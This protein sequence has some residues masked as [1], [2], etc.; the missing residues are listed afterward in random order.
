MRLVDLHWL[1][2]NTDLTNDLRVFSQTGD[3][4]YDNLK[5]IAGCRLDFLQ[6][7]RADRLLQKLASRPGADRD[8]GLKRIRLAILS[9]STVDH[10]EPGLRVAA[11]RHDILLDVMH[12][13][14]GQYLQELRTD[15][16]AL[17]DFRPDV[18]LLSLDAPHLATGAS[19]GMTAADA[20]AFVDGVLDR[21]VA[22][23]RLAREK[24]RAQVIQQTALP[25]FPPLMGSNEA[26]LPGSPAAIVAAINARLPQAAAA[27]GV[28]LLAL[29]A[30]VARDGLFAW[31]DPVLWHRAKQELSPSAG[32][33][34][35]ELVARLIAAQQGKS[36]KCLVLDLDNTLWGGVIGDDG[37]EGIR[38]GQGSTLGEAFVDFQ[39]YARDLSRRGVILAVVSKNDLANAQAP[40][41]SHPDMVLKLT[42]IACFI[43]NWSDKAGNI[44]EVAERLNI[45]LDSLVFVDD[46]PFERNIVRRELP[47]V[48]VPEITDDPA[49]YARAVADGG[50]FEALQITPEDLER[51]GQYRANLARDSLRESHTDLEGYLR[52]LDMVLQ[53]QRFDRIGMQR[54]V[55]LINKTNQFNLRTRRYTDEQVAALVADPACLTLQLRLLDQFGDNGIIGIVIG[56]PDGDTML[57]DTWLM[58]CRVLGRQVEEATMNIVAAEAKR[59]G[60]SQLVGEYIP[61]KKNGMVRDHYKKL[62]FA[63]VREDDGGASSWRLDLA[64]FSPFDTFIALQETSR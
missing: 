47:M 19:P 17:Q 32:P 22:C 63:K 10:L 12:G 31:H 35:G 21:L 40:F 55:Q 43:A 37:L 5:K 46:N 49:L 34:Y 2:V 45:G 8:A 59:L 1:P 36:S 60:A 29:D 27:E 16:A 28:D 24:F 64:T 38:L 9:S 11:L 52:S 53:W 30:T 39:K 33:A 48:A 14:Y 13:E 23:W 51:T 58:S 3:F 50:Y 42:D 62:G 44:R 26:R 57:L 7:T 25:T 61:T 15:D 20:A 6:T 41:E 54:I 4:N 18:V 56:V